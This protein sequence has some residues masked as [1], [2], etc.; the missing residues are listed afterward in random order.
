MVIFFGDLLKFSC[1]D[2]KRFTILIFFLIALFL[3]LVP[4]KVSQQE[5]IL[6]SW[7]N[8]RK[9]NRIK[10]PHERVHLGAKASMLTHSD[11]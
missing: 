9:L 4:R 2:A 11:M 7:S 1:N 8:W 3:V 6:P 10:L 5:H